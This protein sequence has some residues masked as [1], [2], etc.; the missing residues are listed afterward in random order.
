M[1]YLFLACMFLLVTL[2]VSSIE[3]K[4]DVQWYVKV[5]YIGGMFLLDL[6]LLLAMIALWGADHGRW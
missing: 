6:S 4:G 3:F 5:L 2:N 1:A